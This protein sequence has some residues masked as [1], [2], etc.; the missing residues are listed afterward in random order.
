MRKSFH[1][2]YLVPCLKAVYVCVC[3]GW[4]GGVCV[5]GGARFYPQ[6]DNR[7]SRG[8]PFW[9]F[10]IIVFRRQLCIVE[11]LISGTIEVVLGAGRGENFSITER[12]R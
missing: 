9:M 10:H 7:L 5:G 11:I 2:L 4:V 6:D 12:I 1:T 3:V 8:S